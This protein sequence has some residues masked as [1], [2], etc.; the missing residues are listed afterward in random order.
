MQSGEYEA[1]EEEIVPLSGTG[2]W[3][4]LVIASPSRVYRPFGIVGIKLT[5]R[6]RPGHPERIVTG[7]TGEI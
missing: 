2:H 4:H 3:G 6:E 5:E 1:L 7:E